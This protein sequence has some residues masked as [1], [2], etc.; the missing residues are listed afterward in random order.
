MA[1]T[2]SLAR[3]GRLDVGINYVLN[4]D[5]TQERV[6]TAH[7]NCDPGRERRQ[8]LDT[9][10]AYGKENGVMYYHIIQ[11][12]KPGEVTPEQAL[13]IAKAFAEEH[14]PGYETVIAV[15]VDR[16]HI[17]AHLIFNSVNADTGEKYHSNARS[18]YQQIRATSDRLCREYGLSVI[19]E[20]SDRKAV[21]YIEWLRQSKGQPTFRTMLEADLRTAIEDANDLGHFFLLMEH[22]GWEISHGNRLGFRLRGQERFMIPG[23]KNPLFTEEGI[24]AA[25]QGNLSAIES[26]QRPAVIYRPSYHPYKKHPKYTGIMALYVHYLYVL[27]KI[28][29]RQYPPRMTPQLRREVMKSERYREQF[30]FLRENNIA[31]QAD[32]T[33]I[34]A[35]T[36]NALANLMKQRTILNVQ[37]KKRRKLYTALADVSA[38]APAKTLYE[39]GLS[40]M[41]AEYTRYMEAVAVLD[42]CGI[43]R[44]R[45]MAEKAG[46]YEQVA[47]VNRQIRAER[48]KLALCRDILDRLPQMEHDIN[49]IEE[50]EVI[51]DEHRRR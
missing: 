31:T 46:I 4:G 22:K 6:L 35:R 21:S 7:L 38:L 2:K 11:S 49:K 12:F 3:K 5:K 1:I 9:K 28:G 50:R 23:R 16:Q 24:R 25:I 43:P 10:R 45:L 33:A 42:G 14:L 8:M 47:E 18:Y 20:G 30:N 27:G 44:E 51:R 32:M 48:K 17:H 37:K 40:G 29:Q 41:E 15:H 26:G 19:M 13:E 34:Q 39:D 36:E